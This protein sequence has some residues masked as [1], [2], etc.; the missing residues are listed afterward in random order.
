[1]KKNKN[2]LE[3]ADLIDGSE[4]QYDHLRH[5]FIDYLEWIGE[6]WK[7]YVNSKTKKEIKEDFKYFSIHIYLPF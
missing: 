2:V 5:M 7:Q 6:P 1:M 4:Y 3:F